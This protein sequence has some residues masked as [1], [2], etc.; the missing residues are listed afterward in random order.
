VI[1]SGS[2]IRIR[3]RTPENSL[4][5][6]GQIV[7]MTADSLML[8]TSSRFDPVMVPLKEVTHIYYQHG[9]RRCVREGALAG[10]MAGA[11]VGAVIST[12]FAGDGFLD[13]SV[14]DIALA[15]LGLGAV[16][17]VPGA[18][19]GSFFERNKWEKLPFDKMQIRKS[20]A[21]GYEFQM[22]WSIPLQR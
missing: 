14:T 9:R 21:G 12:R 10:F 20:L 6:D 2:Q 16:G 11:T 1:A 4:R 18:L 17:S 7:A 15:V 3:V 22:S 5:Y 8:Q 13:M 19:L